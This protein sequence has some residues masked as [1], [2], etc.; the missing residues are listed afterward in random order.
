MSKKPDFSD[1]RRVQEILD[2]FN[3]ATSVESDMLKQLVKLM[4]EERKEKMVIAI[5]H[6]L[7]M[8]QGEA[9]LLRKLDRALTRDLMTPKE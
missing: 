7:T 1:Q 8:L 9:Q 6:D 5:G 3:R 4:Y 2:T